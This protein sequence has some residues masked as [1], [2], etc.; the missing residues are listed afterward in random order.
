LADPIK[1]LEGRHGGEEGIVAEGSNEDSAGRQPMPQT[2]SNGQY[3]K[4]Y[5]G[6]LQNVSLPKDH[7]VVPDEKDREWY[8]FPIPKEEVETEGFAELFSMLGGKPSTHSFRLA[9]VLSKD[10]SELPVKLCEQID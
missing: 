10:Q 9:I 4:C 2:K 5:W 6:D 3:F 8:C 7:L 1:G